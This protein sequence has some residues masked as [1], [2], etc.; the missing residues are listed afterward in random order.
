MK[1]KRDGKEYTFIF[2]DLI[3]DPMPEIVRLLNFVEGV[4]NNTAEIFKFGD[5]DLEFQIDE[6]KRNLEFQIYAWRSCDKE[7]W[8]TFKI[9]YKKIYGRE[10]IF[11]DVYHCEELAAM[12]KKIIS[13]LLNDEKFPYEYP[14]YGRYDDI[15]F[16][17]VDFQ[18]LKDGKVKIPDS[19]KIFFEK[20]KKMLTNYIIPENWFKL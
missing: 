5:N 19:Y 3:S 4:K 7:I 17:E 2:D 8:L 18:M 15:S 13:D 20:Y 10:I 9:F 14:L 1:I 11:R 6:D 12:L 16:D